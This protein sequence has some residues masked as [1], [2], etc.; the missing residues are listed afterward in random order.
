MQ[1]KEL[2]DFWNTLWPEIYQKYWK[3]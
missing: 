3:F 1:I 2:Q